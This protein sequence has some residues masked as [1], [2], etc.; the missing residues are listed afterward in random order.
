MSGPWDDFSVTDV[1]RSAITGIESGGRYDAIGPR[2]KSGDRAYGKYQVMGS[3]LP[4]WT[5]AALGKVLTPDQFL[6]DP[7]AQEAVFSHR[8]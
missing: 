1:D 3:N 2:T 4:Q 5:Q 7:N 8:F 6:A